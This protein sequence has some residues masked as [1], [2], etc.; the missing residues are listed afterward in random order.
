M[1]T[2]DYS[3]W[4]AFEPAFNEHIGSYQTASMSASQVNRMF[5]L[6]WFLSF[7]VLSLKMRDWWQKTLKTEWKRKKIEGRFDDFRL[8]IKKLVECRATPEAPT[9][10]LRT[11]PRT[12]WAACCTSTRPPGAPCRRSPRRR[13]SSVPC[14]GTRGTEASSM[15]AATRCT[16][17][18]ARSSRR[19]AA[20]C[21]GTRR[22]SRRC[23]ARRRWR[24]TWRTGAV[25]RSS[26]SGCGRASANA[27]RAP[28]EGLGRE[29]P[30]VGHVPKSANKKKSQGCHL[31]VWSHL[32]LI[33]IQELQFFSLIVVMFFLDANFILLWQVH[34]WH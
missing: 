11:E 12:R 19:C 29:G 21:S 20:R 14:G 7:L 5:F 17:S 4:A 8:S 13:H 16:A 30:C 23:G 28:L 1:A 34:V 18:S 6:L 3:S 22:S 26:A 24:H 31:T 27:G 25:T 2:F 10:T 33:Q 32:K 15:A 9:R